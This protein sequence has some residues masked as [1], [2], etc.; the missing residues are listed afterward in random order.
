MSASEIF[1][2]LPKLTIEERLEIIRRIQQIDGEREDIALCL[3]NAEAGFRLLDEM[4]AEDDAR[5]VSR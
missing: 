4:E 1:E 5:R 2:E 3:V